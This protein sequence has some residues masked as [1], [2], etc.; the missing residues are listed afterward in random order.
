MEEFNIPETEYSSATY[1]DRPELKFSPIATGG[2]VNQSEQLTSWLQ[3]IDRNLEVIEME[4]GAIARGTHRDTQV[5]VL[6]G[7]SDLAKEKDSVDS[8]DSDWRG[9]AASNAATLFATLMQRGMPE[10]FTPTDPPKIQTKEPQA[11]TTLAKQ[12]GNIERQLRSADD[13]ADGADEV[14]EELSSLISETDMQLT[15]CRPGQSLNII[16]EDRLDTYLYSEFVSELEIVQ[17]D[18]EEDD[19]THN[20]ARSGLGVWNRLKTLH[21]LS[22]GISHVESESGDF[23][24]DVFPAEH[25]ALA[26]SEEP[27]S[28]AELELYITRNGDVPRTKFFYPIISSQSENVLIDTQL[29]ACARD[30]LRQDE[31]SRMSF[32]LTENGSPAVMEWGRPVWGQQDEI[33]IDIYTSHREID[34]QSADLNECVDTIEQESTT[35]PISVEVKLLGDPPA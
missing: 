26:A 7:I 30:S 22:Y 18:I 9:Y 14:V 25:L 2:W 34:L 1:R 23:A 24:V 29:K 4:A 21:R 13:T 19:S 3:T 31:V 28:Q 10:I 8:D 35:Q 17:E 5:L 16:P 6:R 15:T 33:R 27:S 20:Q 11:Q 32:D 12:V